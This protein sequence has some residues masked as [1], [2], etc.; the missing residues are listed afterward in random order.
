MTLKVFALAKK[1]GLDVR[2][3]S[4]AEYRQLA[5]DVRS[6]KQKVVDGVTAIE[7]RVATSKAVGWRV[8]PLTIYNERRTNCETNEC[9]S[10]GLL[11]GGIPVCHAC[12]CSDKFLDS[13][14]KD[15]R[16]KCPKGRW[17]RHK[18]EKEQE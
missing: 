15:A 18:P 10:F 9:G 8:V 17:H 7:S 16:Q 1:R 2:N 11:A 12:N 4:P 13:K 5:L 6:V 3:L 14:W